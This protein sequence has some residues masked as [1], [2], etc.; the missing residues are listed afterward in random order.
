MDVVTFFVRRPGGSI[1]TLGSALMLLSSL[2]L[3][4][5][6]TSAIA[7]AKRKV[8]SERNRNQEGSLCQRKGE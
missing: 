6:A 8:T 7:V 2:Y 4:V 1:S 5:V 3:L